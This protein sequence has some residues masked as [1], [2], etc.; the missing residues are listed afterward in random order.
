[1]ACTAAAKQAGPHPRKSPNSN[2]I[3]FRRKKNSQD[4]VD[5]ATYKYADIF[6]LKNILIKNAAR[7]FESSV[8]VMLNPS[9]YPDNLV[10]SISK[11]ARLFDQKLVK[12]IKVGTF[13]LFKTI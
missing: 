13:K 11:V 6:R 12:K 10:E 7:T 2:I 5:K 4:L 8:V 1:M 3:A 9:T